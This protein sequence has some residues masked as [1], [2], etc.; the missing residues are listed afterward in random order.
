MEDGKGNQVGVRLQLPRHALP[1]LH[2]WKKR[3]KTMELCASGKKEG[4][5][6]PFAVPDFRFFLG[7]TVWVRNIEVNQ[8]VA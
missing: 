7:F 4:V 2:W 8:L 6:E 5:G 3:P 1:Q